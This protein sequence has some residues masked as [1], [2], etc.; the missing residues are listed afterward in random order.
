[1]SSSAQCFEACT[2]NSV[3]HLDDTINHVITCILV[4]TPFFSGKVERGEKGGKVVVG[5]VAG[6]I[7]VD[8]VREIEVRRVRE[9][10]VDRVREIEVRRVGSL[11]WTGLT[12]WGR[13]VGR[14]GGVRGEK[15]G[16]D[17]GEKG[18]GD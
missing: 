4:N 15:G 1:M 2:M 18:G 14:E 5:R 12:G 8:R 11:R 10:E 17:G 13:L 6:E 16:G 7:E 9:I 3:K